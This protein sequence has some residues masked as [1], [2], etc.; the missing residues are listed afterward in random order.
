MPLSR[1]GG[2]EGRISKTTQNKCFSVFLDQEDLGGE[3]LA[4]L[5]ISGQKHGHSL[6]DLQKLAYKKIR[7]DRGLCKE[8]GFQK[9]MK[10]EDPTIMIDL[11]NNL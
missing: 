1:A 6:P 5:L 9:K 11:F 7:A 4:D 8:E 2:A 10:K 3:I